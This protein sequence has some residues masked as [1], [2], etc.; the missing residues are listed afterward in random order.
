M[1]TFPFKSPHRFTAY[2]S[3]PIKQKLGG[4]ILHNRLD[5]DFS[6]SSQCSLLGLAVFKYSYRS[7]ALRIGPINPKLRRILPDISPRRS[8]MIHMLW[9]MLH[10]ILA[11]VYS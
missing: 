3:Y 5:Q 2:S 7:M 11:L 8:F 6:I 9:A 1:G 10:R 4:M